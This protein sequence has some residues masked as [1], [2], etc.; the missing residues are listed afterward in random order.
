MLPRQIRL[1]IKVMS[2]C[3]SSVM[4]GGFGAAVERQQ[5]HYHVSYGAVARDSRDCVT[6]PEITGG[7]PGISYRKSGWA[8]H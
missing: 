4:S 1:C 2:K 5:P 3:H 6:G 7:V 8:A